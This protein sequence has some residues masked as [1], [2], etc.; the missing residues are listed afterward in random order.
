MTG[1]T[2]RKIII[3]SL[4]VFFLLFSCNFGLTDDSGNIPAEE[5]ETGSLSV[6]L[7]SSS[8]RTIYPAIDMAMASFNVDGS[9]PGGESFSGM[10]LS[11]TMYTAENLVTGTWTITVE[12]KNSAGAII[13]SGEKAV[14]IVSGENAVSID[15][16]PLTDDG[17]FSFDVSWPAD[18]LNLS[19]TTITSTFTA[20]GGNPIYMGFAV[21]EE[22]VSH[23]QSFP[24]GYYTWNLKIEEYGKLRYLMPPEVVRI[25]S[26]EESSTSVT[27]TESDIRPLPQ[28]A[29][30]I[31]VPDPGGTSG[32]QSITL[33]CGTPGAVV[34][35]TTNGS[36]PTE[37]NGIEYTT[38]FILNSTTSLK[39]AAYH[40]EEGW[41]NSDVASHIITVDGSCATPMF[42][43]PPGV[44]YTPV[45]VEIISSTSGA[46]IKYTTDG[47][48]IP[49]AVSGSIYAG[50]IPLEQGEAELMAIAKA[51]VSGDTAEEVSDMISGLFKVTGTL[52]VPQADVPGGTFNIP[53]EVTLTCSNPEVD[54]YYTID[55][56][57]PT[58]QSGILFNTLSPV[59]I[60][61]TSTLKAVAVLDDW[62]DSEILELHYD[63]KCAIP[64]I[65]VQSLV[66]FDSDQPVIRFQSETPDVIFYYTLDGTAPSLTNG[67]T[68]IGTS[69]SAGISLRITAH[70]DNWIDSGIITYSFLG[71]SD[72][73]FSPEDLAVITDTTPLLNWVDTTDTKQY[74]IQINEAETFDG[75]MI[76][77]DNSV[78][79]SEYLLTT[80]LTNKRTYYWRLKKLNNE[81]AWS[82]WSGVRKFTIRLGVPVT[83]QTGTRLYTSATPTLEWAGIPEARYYHLQLKTE[84]PLPNG[85]IIQETA[86]LIDPGYTTST[87]PPDKLGYS[88]RVRII[89]DDGV[90]SDWSEYWGFN[91]HPTLNLKQGSTDIGNINHGESGI[92]DFGAVICDGDDGSSSINVTFTVENTGSFFYSGADILELFEGDIED[93]DLDPNGISTANQLNLNPGDTHDFHIR[94]DPL[95][96]GNKTAEVRIGYTYY[97]GTETVYNYKFEVTGTSAPEIAVTQD[98]QDISSG[99]GS[100]GFGNVLTDGSGGE[101]SESADFIIENEGTSDLNIANI[102]LSSGDVDDFVITDNTVTPILPGSTT[103]F[104]IQFDP[105]TT[106]ASGLKSA[107]VSIITDDE[108]ESPYIFSVNG[109]G[110]FS[111]IKVNN[112]V[113]GAYYASGGSGYDF[114]N[115][116]C[117]GE[118]GSTSG[119]VI[120]Y[121]RN[122]GNGDLKIYDLNFTS[123]DISDFDLI[124]NTVKPQAPFTYTNPFSIRF[125]PLT[126][127]NKFAVI[128]I[129][130]NDPDTPVYILNMAGNSNPEINIKQDTTDLSSGTG[131]FDFGNI[132]ADGDGNNDSGDTVFTIENT[133]GSE[134]SITNIS[135]TAGDI[136]N[137][138]LTDNST[139]TVGP[140]GSTTFSIS[141]DPLTSGEK[142]ATVTIENSDPDEGTYTFNLI[143]TGEYPDI[144]V[145]QDAETIVNGSHRVDL[146]KIT[147]F[148]DG[149]PAGTPLEFT[150]ENSGLVDLT[151]SSIIF[152]SGDTADFD[153]TNSIVSSIPPAGSGSFT[154]RFDPLTEGGKTALVSITSDDPDESP[155]TFEINGNDYDPGDIGPAGGY[156]FYDAGDYS[157]GW[158]YLEAAHESEGRW[159]DRTWGTYPQL[160]GGTNADVGYGQTNTTIIAT[161][162]D[163]NS[164][165]NTASQSCRDLVT[166]SGHEDW[167]LPSKGEMDLVYQNLIAEGIGNWVDGLYWCSTESST[168]L[169]WYIYTVTGAW[170]EQTLYF[171][172]RAQ[173][174]RDF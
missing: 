24:A 38:P 160:I 19:A 97:V 62:I 29:T 171:N 31:V 125:D 102:T 116:I 105:L 136:G 137:F 152:S 161:W 53:R 68:G 167:F 130:T 155:Y 18:N 36:T 170:S 50:A 173:A 165:S 46:G 59:L 162:C 90:A 106:D 109:R 174:I 129:S 20:V 17:S 71:F 124:D 101:I 128:S 76:A 61:K 154:V 84:Y 164:L 114:G 89:N 42:N 2:G 78:T 27:L 34:K 144:N 98:T 119:Y 45:D 4:I 60:E 66:V 77:D 139:A 107:V 123:G 67:F 143:G 142:T 110:T 92:H 108:D 172:L 111:D 91:T 151:I 16:Y 168:S 44:Y 7:D 82:T 37:K 99:T 87:L 33:L 140:S 25:I 52:E 148:E 166:A 48:T 56:S 70:R 153:L 145:K 5:S 73:I 126:A 132:H 72:S 1:L 39:A 47:T 131:S 57:V 100:H 6:N 158:R 43:P 41:R 117:D 35:Y 118:D 23:S 74:Q 9:G 32:S 86:N 80:I 147:S 159:A 169:G 85:E 54:I 14:E 122:L 112:K 104:A 55:G 83:T 79:E 88:W 127:G 133:G 138:D 156:I 13:L 64:E 12:G 28:V 69:V 26:F 21:T 115:I 11:G 65:N 94:F 121:I 141:F 113:T 51:D 150:I 10:D 30:P 58:V 135:I 22:L 8:T 134:L 163:N 49:D 96:A 120:F 103:S 93:F 3:L 15:L 75:V 81:D 95:T 149:D 63:M 40:P 146:G 157:N